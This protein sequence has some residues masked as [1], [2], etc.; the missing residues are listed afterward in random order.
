MVHPVE[1]EDAFLYG[2]ALTLETEIFLTDWAA[3]LLNVRERML[4]GSSVGKF[5]TQ[6]GLGIRFIIN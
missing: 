3:L 4:F 1:N 6:I 2:A 5:N